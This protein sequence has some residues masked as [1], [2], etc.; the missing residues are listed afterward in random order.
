MAARSQGHFFFP[1][2][3]RG[4]REDEVVGAL[5]FE[6]DI[7][8][9]P[10][11]MT[12]YERLGGVFAIATVVDDF[13][14]RIMVDPRLNANPKVNEA[15]HKVARAGFK[16]LVTEQVCA[17]AGGPQRYTGRSMRD[18]HAQLDISE[19][20]WQAFLDDFRQTLDQFKVPTTE[21][22]E[23]FAIVESTKGD[24]VLHAGP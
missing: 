14:D 17:A 5:F 18:S 9:E 11:S 4:D 21:Q 8:K 16:Y 7:P 22:A 23:L 20:E 12:L 10:M 1:S 2:R 19:E 6:N 15:H 24:I 13:I 3:P